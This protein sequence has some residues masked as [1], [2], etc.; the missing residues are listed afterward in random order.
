MDRRTRSLWNRLR[1]LFGG[2]SDSAGNEETRQTI[3][4]LEALMEGILAELAVLRQQERARI[5]RERED[6]VLGY[7][8]ESPVETHYR[9][10]SDFE[11]RIARRRNDADT[12]FLEVLDENQVVR[13][14][15]LERTEVLLHALNER[16]VSVIR[17]LARIRPRLK[18]HLT[19]ILAGIAQS[20]LAYFAYARSF[21]GPGKKLWQ[22]AKA[23]VQGGLVGAYC[24]GIGGDEQAMINAALSG[25]AAG[26][27]L[28]LLNAKEKAES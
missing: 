17:D 9:I 28:N 23:D 2:L 24:A 5:V 27:V 16:N 26:S 7:R 15:E 3:E 18:T 8:L 12:V 19:R 13:G 1:S 21:V 14:E 4:E 25:A 10:V 20:D 6:A 22:F 11:E